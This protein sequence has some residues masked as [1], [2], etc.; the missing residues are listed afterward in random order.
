VVSEQRPPEGFV[1]TLIANGWFL[2]FT[3]YF[4][5]GRENIQTML[6]DF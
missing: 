5:K 4:I 6:G 3:V 1:V 2:A